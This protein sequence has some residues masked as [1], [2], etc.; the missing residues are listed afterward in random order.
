MVCTLGF[1]AIIL[2]G[3]VSAR[4]AFVITSLSD[5]L[6]IRTNLR[7]WVSPW[8][9]VFFWALSFS[10]Y[11]VPLGAYYI[12][13]QSRRLGPFAVTGLSDGY[14]FSYVSITTAS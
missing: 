13:W 9:D 4:A 14:W 5:D 12:Y 10:L 8:T 7:R 1:L 11:L 2:F 3:G 6:L